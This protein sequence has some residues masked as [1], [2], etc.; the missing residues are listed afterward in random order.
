[1]GWDSGFEDNGDAYLSGFK[2]KLTDSTALVYTNAW[3]ASTTT[4]PAPPSVN[5]VRST[6][7]F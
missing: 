7:R 2:R 4:E 3:V 5:V 6:A 1:M